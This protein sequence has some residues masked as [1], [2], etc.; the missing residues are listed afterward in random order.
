[1]TKVVIYTQE[2]KKNGE[3]VLPQHLFTL[4]WSDALVHQT[5]IGMANN[6]RTGAHTKDR[7]EVRGGGRKPWRQK[8]TD[9]ARHGS[10]RSPLWVGGGVTFGPKKEKNYS[11]SLNKKMRTK[12]FFTVLSEKFRGDAILFLDSFAVDTPSTKTAAACITAIYG[13]DRKQKNH[14]TVV[15]SESNEAMRKSFSN[16][17]GVRTIALHAFNAED[18][19]TAEKI[20][21]V[22]PE[23]TVEH[24]EIRGAGIKSSTDTATVSEKHTE[25]KSVNEVEKKNGT[26]KADKK[27]I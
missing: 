26:E 15:F 17:Q 14:C 24:L 13:E 12:A 4:P 5:V 23:K 9:R 20:L 10:I 2:G 7:A 8:G 11:V 21:F 27:D 25:K 1:M 22:H 19:L 3:V 6:R 18:A 16:L